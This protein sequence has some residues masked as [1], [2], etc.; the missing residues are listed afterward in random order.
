MK[1]KQLKR[2][3]GRKKLAL[4]GCIGAMMVMPLLPVKA[5]AQEVRTYEADGGEIVSPRST[6]YM[7]VYKEM[8]GKKY[9]RLW[10][11]THEE[12]VT[13]WILCP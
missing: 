11:A 3:A 5:A 13:D 10:D 7:W 12:W 6:Q 1:N 9:R 8:N 4:L 2:T